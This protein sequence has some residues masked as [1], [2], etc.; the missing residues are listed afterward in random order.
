[1]RGPMDSPTGLDMY[2]RPPAAV[3]VR[4]SIGVALLII[5]ALIAMAI[6]YGVY[7]RQHRQYQ[8]SVI[9]NDERKARPATTAGKEVTAGIVPADAPELRQDGTPA[10]NP[11]PLAGPQELPLVSPRPGASAQR[12]PTVLAAPTFPFASGNPEDD[13]KA[14]AFQKEQ[15]AIESPMG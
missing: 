15:Q 4:R 2:P 5:L 3:R 11:K 9:S 8:V 10:E 13:E 6:V 1:M 7:E 12:Q 14:R